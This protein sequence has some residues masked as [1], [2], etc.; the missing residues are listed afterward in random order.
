[1][2]TRCAI[3][4]AAKRS[5]RS[6]EFQDYIKFYNDTDLAPNA[7]FYIGQIRYSQAQFDE[8]IQEFDKVLEA[9]PNNNKTAAA[10]YYKGKTLFQ[11]SQRT[12][13][14]KEFQ[15]VIAE[16]PNSD[17]APQARAQLK[18]L[19][20]NPGTAAPVRRKRGT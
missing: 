16:F 3:C 11:L 19:G 10:H 4:R 20:I 2:R 7:Q 12:A 6:S 14:A 8:A 9:Y 18:V 13:A 1:M 5:W 17:V 15:A